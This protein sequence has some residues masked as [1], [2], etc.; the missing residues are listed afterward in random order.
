M[1]AAGGPA[2]AENC[3][4]TGAA[5]RKLRPIRAKIESTGSGRA[6]ELGHGLIQ[7]RTIADMGFAHPLGDQHAAHLGVG[8]GDHQLPALTR[9]FPGQKLERPRAGRVDKGHLGKIHDIGAGPV[10]DPFQDRAEARRRAWLHDAG[11]ISAEHETDGGWDIRVNWSARQAEAF[12]A[13]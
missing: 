1:G 4:R 11:V 2:C 10:G 6:R 9:A 13:L 5:A 8:P 7:G 3:E 12:A